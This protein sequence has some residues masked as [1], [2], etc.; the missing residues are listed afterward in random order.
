MYRKV[1]I[2][3]SDFDNTQSLFEVTRERALQLSI[4]SLLNSFHLKSTLIL[5]RSESDFPY[6]F[7]AHVVVNVWDNELAELKVFCI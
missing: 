6:D 1:G 4:I 5:F 3:K 7:E 2:Q